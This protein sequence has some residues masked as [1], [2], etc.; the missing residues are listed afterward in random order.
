MVD[1]LRKQRSIGQRC[2]ARRAHDV[3][4]QRTCLD[5]GG[6]HG[7]VV[8]DVASVYFD[9]CPD[10]DRRDNVVVNALVNVVVDGTIDRGTSNHGCALDGG[11]IIGSLPVCNPAADRG[12]P[13]LRFLDLGDH[14]RHRGEDDP[15]LARGLSGT[16]RVSAARHRDALE[17]HRLGNHR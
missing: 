15:F 9:R 11:A 17:L 3:I 8:L 16:S 10:H 6:W 13:R 4:D 14:R 7:R 5:D 12:R 2:R 1:L